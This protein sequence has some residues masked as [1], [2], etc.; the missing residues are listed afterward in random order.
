M[1]WQRRSSTEDSRLMVDARKQRGLLGLSLQI[2]AASAMAL[3]I[4]LYAAQKKQGV[5]YTLYHTKLDDTSVRRVKQQRR[6]VHT[7]RWCASTVNRIIKPT[8]QGA[9]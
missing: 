2:N 7:L 6:N 4:T 1:N 9:R 3:V 8:M 5:E